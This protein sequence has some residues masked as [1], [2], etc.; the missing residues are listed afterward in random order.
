[1]DE[2]AKARVRLYLQ[3]ERAMGL[4]AVP[5]VE[6]A[7]E[8]HPADAPAVLE[9][10]VMAA[11]REPPRPKLPVKSPA[12]A[13]AAKPPINTPGDKA[14]LKSQGLIPMPMTGDFTAPPLATD[15]KRRRLIAMDENEVRGC[16]KCRLCET[17]THTVFGEGDVDA[18]I[19]FIGEGPGETEDQTGRPFVGRAGELLNKMIAG[20]GLNREQVY[21]ANVVKCLRY[22]TLVQ[23]ENGGWERIG[24]LVRQRYA[25]RVMSVAENGAIVPR[26]VTGWHASPL[27]GRRVFKLSYASSA[28]RGG[29]RAVTYLTHDHEVLTRR[30]WVMAERLR[31]DDEIA[32]GQGFSQTAYEVAVGSLLG[33]GSIVKKNA[34]LG[35][36]HSSQQ[37]EYVEF[38]AR[39]LTELNPLVYDG[40]CTAKPGGE[41]HPTT[42]CR[43]KA[44]R[45]LRVLRSRFYSDHGKRIPADFRLTAR[46]LAIWFL[47]DGHMRIRPG[48]KP[49]AELAAHSFDAED[50]DRLIEHLKSDLSLE[51]YTRTSSPGRIHFDVNASRRLAE[52]VAP[53]APPSMRYKLHADVADKIRF[54]P[55]LFVGEQPFTVFDRVSIEPVAFEGTD[56]TFFCLDVEETNNFVTSGGV[57]HNCRPPNNRVPAPDEVATCTPYLERQLE[58]VRPRAIVTLGLPATQ[59]MLQTKMSMG[60]LRGTWHA[61]RGIHLM[62]T[63]HPAYVLRNPT[64]DTRA[65]VWSDLKQVLA[66]LGLPVPSKIL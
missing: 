50:I 27:A 24:R 28:L 66:H 12:Q 55:A 44:K 61:W 29:N 11:R 6:E 13:P 33:D 56:K 25:G 63:Y 21:I 23:L 59:Y 17:R 35:I 30:G 2:S 38:K 54:K 57:V 36:V 16:T 7:P 22:S 64:Y 3:S 8:S 9:P 5:R 20:M 45:A 53:F 37:R 4:S 19:F 65:A 62:P 32:V 31:T 14:T 46:I 42:V 18:P 58:I 10:P 48:K 49:L 51:A 52:I 47:D 1:M 40:S 34:Y 15:E 60:K 39:A 26:R 43:T 41:R